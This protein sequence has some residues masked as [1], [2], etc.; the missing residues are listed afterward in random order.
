[1]ALSTFVPYSAALSVKQR[2]E[3]AKFART[4]QRTHIVHCVVHSASPVFV[5]RI[6]MRRAKAACEEVRRLVRG[7]QATAVVRDLPSP[8][9]ARR[10]GVEAE[11]LAR[12]V[13]LRFGGVAERPIG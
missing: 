7:V 9:V 11:S 10:M 12:Y 1:M 6:M 5:S 13:I 4:I 3:I 2:A 8:R